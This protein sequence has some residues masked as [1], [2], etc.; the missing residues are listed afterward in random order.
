MYNLGM[1]QELKDYMKQRNM[2]Q[3][4]M[5]RKLGV[6]F[7]T[8]NRWLNGKFRPSKLALEKIE[9]VLNGK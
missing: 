6:S 9:K 4:E 7:T 2:T 5:A 1:I 8:L 3:E